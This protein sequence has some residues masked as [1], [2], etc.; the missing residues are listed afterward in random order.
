MTVSRPAVRVL[1]ADDNRDAADSLALMLAL[2]GYDTR[3]VYDGERACATAAEFEPDACLLD[4]HMPGVDGCEVARRVRAAFGHR[5]LLVAITGVT[6]GEY[7]ER[8]S[9]AGF[10]ARFAKPCDP[11]ELMRLLSAV[12][13]R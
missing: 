9:R 3:T 8:V 5:V 6:G 11:N 12:C 1:V 4:V 2:L 13:P 7:D 10:N